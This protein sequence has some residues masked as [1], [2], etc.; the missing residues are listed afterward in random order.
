MYRR[1][2]HSKVETLV[3]HLNSA[4]EPTNFSGSTPGI[5][6][7]MQVVFGTPSRACAGSG[8]CKM[9]PLRVK[10]GANYH[11]SIFRASCRITS[12]TLILKLSRKQFTRKQWQYWFAGGK[13]CVEEGFQLPRWISRQLP[14]SAYCILPGTYQLQGTGDTVEIELAG[15]ASYEKFSWRKTA[16]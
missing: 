15:L 9:L 14:Y 10:L 4:I 7:S 13:F 6:L 11:C 16:V 2:S 5:D 12:G 3:N 1:K 8:V